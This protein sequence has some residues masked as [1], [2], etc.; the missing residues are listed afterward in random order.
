MK[1][2]IG[3]YIHVPFCLKKCLYCSFY[4][5]PVRPEQLL[6][7]EYVEALNI[8]IKR[9][10]DRADE[11][12]IGTIY[13]GG[14]TPTLL[15]AQQLASLLENLN[16]HFHLLDDIEFTV[17][18]NP[19]TIDRE[20]AS[21]LRTYGVNRISLGMQAAQDHLLSL[22]GRVHTYESTLRSY[23]MIKEAGFE[24][25]NVDLMYGLPRQTTKEWLHTLKE[26][27][28]LDPDHISAYSL[29]LE[30]ATPL[31]VQHKR[32]E[33]ALPSEEEEELM[34]DQ[35]EDILPSRGFSRYEI[36]SY[37]KPQK[38]C[39]HNQIYWLN[40][41]YTG[42]GAAAFSYADRCREKNI[43]RVTEYLFRIFSDQSAKDWQERLS[44]ENEM[45]E[46]M[47]MGLRMKRGVR[48]SYFKDRF[49]QDLLQVFGQ[50]I[51]YLQELGLVGMDEESVFP[52]GKGFRYNNAVGREFVG[53]QG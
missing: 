25:V 2:K 1:K 4:S 36:S 29:F 24:N 19:G 6:V 40:E 48:F 26:A 12:E 51:A 53:R 50:E 22:I 17:E 23:E 31:A 18:A 5:E 9:A 34:Y 16:R 35:T 44:L 45:G 15:S 27:V 46:T 32:G 21:I 14:G 30:E 28:R 49:G 11:K 52:T 37:A 20:K 42:L 38:E 33:T 8:E 47:M 13:M 3:L 10:A 7:R 39:L 41:E 43:N